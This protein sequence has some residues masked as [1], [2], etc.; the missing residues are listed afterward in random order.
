MLY[1]MAQN[2]QAKFTEQDTELLRQLFSAGEKH[3]WKQ[4]TKQINR[5]SLAR[6][7]EPL[8]AV[9]SEDERLGPLTLTKNVLP[10]YV[11]KQYQNLLGLPKNS[12]YFGVLGSSLPYVV[13]ENG[14]ND[15]DDSQPFGEEEHS[16]LA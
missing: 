1:P 9:S 12:V 5:R 7:G 11:I 15:L 16:E 14:W 6:R 2:P 10:T 4:I 3:K 13:A 8:L